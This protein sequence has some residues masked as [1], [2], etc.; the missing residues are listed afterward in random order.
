[1]SL[2]TTLESFTVLTTT[3]GSCGCGCGCN[4]FPLA[5]LIPPQPSPV[6][7]EGGQ[8]RKRLGEARQGRRGS[9]NGRR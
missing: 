1:M 2:P 8:L 9:G 6:Q 4:D 5:Q 3:Q 7:E